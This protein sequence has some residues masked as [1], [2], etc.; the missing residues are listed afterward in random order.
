VCTITRG[1]EGTIALVRRHDADHSHALWQV[2]WEKG[3]YVHSKDFGL[4]FSDALTFYDKIKG[5]RKGVTLR[6]KNI[7]FEPPLKYA[8]HVPL[9]KMKRVR[10]LKKKVQVGWKVKYPLTYTV[11]MMLVNRRG[12]WWCP[13][14]IKFRR[15]E[16]HKWSEIEG[17]R[18]DQPAYRC[19]T[20]EI[21]N[22]DGSVKRFNPIAAVLEMK[23]RR[24]RRK[25]R[26]R[27]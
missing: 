27:R 8:D 26:G 15:F 4:Y 23:L 6:C 11:R 9:Y 24:R 22:Y 13:Y 21:S 5:K 18:M 17:I 3:D 25:K 19:P 14:C 12:L 2:V 10:G 7:S 16:L 20:C 1:K